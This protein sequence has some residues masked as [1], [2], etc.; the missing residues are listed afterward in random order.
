MKST[1]KVNDRHSHNSKEQTTHKSSQP[2]IQLANQVSPAQALHRA[3]ELQG[4]GL[5][6]DDV[7]TLHRVLGNRGV[8]RLLSGADH[9][10]SRPRLTPRRMLQPKLTVGSADDRY[11]READ[12][13]ASQIMSTEDAHV[14]SQ[15]I[16]PLS[17]EG[18][19]TRESSGVATS[20]TLTPEDVPVAQVLL[21]KTERPQDGAGGVELA[22]DI[23]G[24]VTAQAS[25]GS[26][27]ST[28]VRSFMEPR[29]G[30]DFSGV[31]IHTDAKSDR[32][33]RSLQARAFTVGH[34]IFFQRGA[35]DPSGRTGRELLAHELTHVVQQGGGDTLRRQHKGGAGRLASENKERSRGVRIRER[36]RAK[37]VV[38]RK[39]GLELELAVP[40]DKLGV[41]SDE[42]KKILNGEKKDDK[43]FFELRRNA[44]AGYGEFGSIAKLA[45]AADHS[46]RVIPK[47][48]KFPLRVLSKSILELVFKPPVETKE[49]LTA[50]INAAKDLVKRIDT[51]TG[52]LKKRVELGQGG[53]HIG[54][55]D[56]ATA[57]PELSYK[58][59]IHVN[60]GIDPRRLHGMLGW[61]SQ[62][63]Y[64]P[65][66][67]FRMAPIEHALNV[68]EEIVKAF[69][70]ASQVKLG[71]VQ[72]WNGL[73]GLTALFVMYLTYG[74]DTSEITSSVK[75]FA[76]IL[77]KTPVSEIYQ[78]G[79][80]KEEKVWLDATWD[81]YKKVLIEKTRAKD[82]DE[83]AALILRTEPGSKKLKSNWQIKDLFDLKATAPPLISQGKVIHADEVGPVRTAQDKVTGGGRRKGMVLEFRSLPGRYTPD[84]WQK[85][86][87]DFLAEADK[88]HATKDY[89]ELPPPVLKPK[90]EPEPKPVSVPESQ[91][92]PKP[93]ARPLPTPVLKPKP[94]VP[95]PV[96]NVSPVQN[97]ALPTP[98]VR[99]TVSSPT[100]VSSVG[101]KPP[102]P[103]NFP[104]TKTVVQ[105]QFFW[106][107]GKDVEWEGGLW[108]VTAKTGVK[109]YTLKFIRKL[110]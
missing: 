9:K 18:E 71:D 100:V 20:R 43:R 103:S 105:T 53:M 93:E 21:R 59:M 45:L 75:N 51:A 32:L 92:K 109:T 98:P 54:P 41:I 96:V 24:E 25:A 29:F 73:R 72:F 14:N 106:T 78:H 56:G 82:V 10:P 83:S 5:K 36:G 15:P 12:K 90:P 49:E 55:L 23:E 2:S 38:Q 27:L 89:Q 62:S 102:Q 60:L 110:S 107:V 108:N 87:E 48:E 37:G 30:A 69:T 85:V 22:G 80:T 77:T 13:I 66:A 35:F 4:V 33:N 64:K 3:V 86:A 31:K 67:K 17:E 84:Q 81:L 52:G 8:Q 97:L 76:S 6:A 34:N 39:I 47:V 19:S 101:I 104:A 94:S 79:L 58:A 68:A 40:I 65:P 91:P 63:D 28:G 44:D 16:A 70:D 1:A 74:A 88:Q 7:N 26:P 50:S 95:K 42:D 61:Y 46:S 57:P 11:E 99:A